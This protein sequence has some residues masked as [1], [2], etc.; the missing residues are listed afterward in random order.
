MIG[1]SAAVKRAI[2]AA[3]ELVLSDNPGEVPPHLRS[4]A[5]EGDREFG[6]GVGYL[7][8]HGDPLAVVAQQYLP[9]GLEQATVFAP[10]RVGEESDLA[11]RLARIDKILGKSRGT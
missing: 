10:K 11:D 8:P 9:D 6:F 2:G 3:K 4:G 1:R 7:Y 5:T